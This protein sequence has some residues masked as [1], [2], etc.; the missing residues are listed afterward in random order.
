M[1][2]KISNYALSQI[3]EQ[4]SYI[5]DSQCSGVFTKTIGLPCKHRLKSLAQNNQSVKLDEVHLQWLLNYPK[6]PEILLEHDYFNH[7]KESLIQRVSKSFDE[8]SP[9]QQLILIEKIDLFINNQIPDILEPSTADVLV[10]G[11]K[12]ISHEKSTIRSRSEFEYFEKKI[13]GNIC[14]FCLKRGH[15]KRTCESQTK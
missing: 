13:T 10:K 4:L 9:E 11:R 15:N 3:Y 5:D 7:T 1:R 12:T 2:H 6:D 14:S 8:I